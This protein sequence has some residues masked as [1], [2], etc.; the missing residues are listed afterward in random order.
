MPVTMTT[1]TMPVAPTTPPTSCGER[2]VAAQNCLVALSF[3]D[4]E[5]GFGL[6]QSQTSSAPP[7]L[8]HTKDGGSTWQVIS[9]VPPAL[10]GY[11]R[12]TLLFN[13]ALNG[14]VFD[15]SG[16]FTTHDAGLAWSQVML[17]GRME[18]LAASSGTLW[19]VLSSCPVGGSTSA[20][21]RLAI[22]TSSDSGRSWQRLARLP[23]DPFE[24]AQL[25]LV[26]P[27]TVFLLGLDNHISPDL[28]GELFTTTDAGSTW[29]TRT[30]PCP[31]HYRLS[32]ALEKAASSNTLW[33]MCNGQGSAGHLGIIIYRSTDDGLTWLGESSCEVGAPTGVRPEAPCGNQEDFVAMSSTEAF[34]L[35]LN[36]G[37]MLTT[38]G[39]VKWGPVRSA[40][41]QHITAGFLGSL[42]FANPEVG[43]A[44]FWVTVG[45][46]TGLWHTTDGGAMWSPV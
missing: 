16:F 37:L 30:L 40:S 7:T 13:N 24:Q 38:D 12:P 35:S 25:V 11:Y 33:L 26:S 15:A 2:I 4:K 41:T 6:Y 17:P 39:G 18:N 9:Q 5:R 1:P 14:F 19:A 32:G 36:G 29:T 23:T 44:A 43:W 10:T 21:C 22:E 28:P 20:R 27:H 34:D 31:S 45:N 42:D 3:I 8:V 46:H